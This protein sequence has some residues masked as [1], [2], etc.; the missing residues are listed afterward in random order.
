MEQKSYAYGALK[1]SGNQVAF[2]KEEFDEKCFFEGQA[3]CHLA[4]GFQK[5]HVLE[6][7]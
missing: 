4:K 3:R 1:S 5:D 6:D 7:D 2:F